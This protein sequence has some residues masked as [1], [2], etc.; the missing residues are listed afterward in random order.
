[1]GA[2]LVLPIFDGLEGL[3]EAR[4]AA[5]QAHAYEVRAA[6][7]SRELL[8]RFESS[9]QELKLAHDLVHGAERNVEQARQYL[10]A[11]LSEYAR[12]LKNSP[13]VL[14]ASQRYVDS[15]RRLADLRRD[16]QL[17]RADLLAML[18]R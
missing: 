14:G 7:T 5:K 8:A 13:D 9:R 4:S 2:R 6:Q 12:G 15:R 16:Y 10:A 1:M 11:T 3:A 17:A 18:G